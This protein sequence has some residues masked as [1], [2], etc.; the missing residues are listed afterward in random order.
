MSSRPEDPLHL[1]FA[2]AEERHLRDLAFA[3]V[4]RALQALSTWYVERRDGIRAGRALD[5]AGKR[6]AFALFYGPMHFSV[7]REILRE[8]DPEGKAP[9]RIHDLGC[10]TGAAG[11][12]WAAHAAGRPRLDGVDLNRWAVEEANRSGSRLGLKGRARTGR[13][14]RERAP[15]A[16]DAALLAYTVNELADDVR[17]ALLER[18]L[19]TERPRLLV[20]E[21]ISRRVAPWWDRWS[22]RIADAGGRAD[23]WRFPAR[24][25]ERWHLLGRAAGLDHRELTA[26]SLYLP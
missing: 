25:P 10:G 16:R 24:L 22:E 13:L 12:A 14:E 9:E 15:G 17:A 6:A 11:A 21:P 23:R 18:L 7:T 2:V 20:I 19:G 5:S 4:R 8:V 1:W 26:R 3:E